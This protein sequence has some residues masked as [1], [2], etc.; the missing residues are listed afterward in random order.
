LLCKCSCELAEADVQA[1]VDASLATVGLAG[2]QR[3]SAHTLSGGERQRLAVAGA[4][5][6][7]RAALCRPGFA[8][9]PHF[10]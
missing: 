7:A 5:A 10:L 3:R 2:F 6:Q 1:V 9:T 4:L 8:A